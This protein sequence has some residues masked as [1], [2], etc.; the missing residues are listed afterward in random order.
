MEMQ[1]KKIHIARLKR[2]RMNEYKMEAKEAL[3]NRKSLD[4]SAL[5]YNERGRRIEE[6]Y[7]KALNDKANEKRTSEVSQNQDSD[8]S[9]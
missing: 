8:E 9:D 4:D 6:G 1:M 7:L 3:R 5:E 2:K